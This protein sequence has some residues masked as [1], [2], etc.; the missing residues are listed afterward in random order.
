MR[1]KP[2]QVLDLEQISVIMIL[3]KQNKL[4][5]GKRNNNSKDNKSVVKTPRSVS[6]VKIG[7]KYF[8]ELFCRLETHVGLV[9]NHYIK[10]N[11][12]KDDVDFLLTLMTSV[13]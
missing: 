12:R 11:L 10:W 1:Y 7:L 9:L 4:F 2:G 6:V 5:S 3:R 13:N 8:L